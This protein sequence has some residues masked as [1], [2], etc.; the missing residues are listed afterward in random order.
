MLVGVVPASDVEPEEVEQTVRLL[1]SSVSYIH[2]FINDE[3]VTRRS[4]VVRRCNQ[5]GVSVE[6]H[7]MY[8][9]KSEALRRAISMALARTSCES[10]LQIDGHLKVGLSG[11]EKVV[12]EMSVGEELMVIGDRY[13]VAPPVG[14]HRLTLVSIMSHLTRQLA[15]F[16]LVD[17]VCGLRAYSRNLA[18]QFVGASVSHGYG[19]EVEQ[20]VIAGK[21]GASVVPVQ[22]ELEVPQSSMTAASKLVDNFSVILNRGR[23][24]LSDDDYALLSHVVA[25]I[26]RDRTFTLPCKAFG[27]RR[28]VKFEFVPVGEDGERCYAL[29]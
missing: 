28:S 20:I 26:S 13:G 6:S 18:A 27:L 4:A 12:R 14:L 25:G 9:G 29:S 1:D 22:V 2:F 21:V 16:K 8:L 10:V 15:P 5:L 19:I 24:V 17:C 7:A 3:N 23:G 11:V